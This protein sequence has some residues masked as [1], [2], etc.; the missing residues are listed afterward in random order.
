M[1]NTKGGVQA[2]REDLGVEIEL[3]G[4][5]MTAY[6]YGAATRPELYNA[7]EASEP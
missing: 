7:S 2:L 1:Q 3:N 6:R 4:L 5:A